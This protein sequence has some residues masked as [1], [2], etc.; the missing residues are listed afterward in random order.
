[1]PTDLHFLL[2]RRLYHQLPSDDIAPGFL[3]SVH[4]PPIAT[5]LDDLIQAG[6]FRRAAESALTDLLTSNPSDASRI[7]KLLY[8]RLACLVVISRPDLA[9]DEA[10]PLSDFLNRNTPEARDTLPLVP[11]DLRLLLVRLQSIAAADGGRRA[12]MSLYALTSEVRSH[13]SSARESGDETSLT[14]WSARL[15]DLGLRVADS[16]VEIGELET[17]SRHVDSLHATAADQDTDS[18]ALHTRK[19]L[20]QIRLGNLSLAAQTLSHLPASP[21]KDLHHAL[22]QTAYGDFATSA[23]TWRS[24]ATQSP[25]NELLAQNAATCLLYAN[26]IT[27]AREVLETLARHTAAFP[28]LLFNLSTVY[29]LCSERAGELKG[30]LAREFAQR[31]PGV[32]AV[33]CGGWERGVGEFKL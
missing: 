1:M 25:S 13:I 3:E 32:E 11:W 18:D 24:L 15:R 17:A 9:A 8:T 23:S 30:G 31:Q 4:Q 10:V 28:V 14:L 22:L 7:F 20:L 2:D 12:I 29:E 26:R 21:T 27:E 19:A 33:G 5:P 16:L 6:H